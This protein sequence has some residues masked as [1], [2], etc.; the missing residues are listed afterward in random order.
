MTDAGVALR[1]AAPDGVGVTATDRTG[2]AATNT[3]AGAAVAGVGAGAAAAVAGAG[4]DA[5]AAASW[6]LGATASAGAAAA[7]AAAGA[8]AGAAGAAAAAAGA[9]V[10]PGAGEGSAGDCGGPPSP[11]QGTQ[12][13]LAP[14]PVS[15]CVE[16]GAGA[17]GRRGA[18]A[19]V[20][21][22]GGAWWAVQSGVRGRAWG[23]GDGARRTSHSLPSLPLRLV[24]RAKCE[25]FSRGGPCP[26]NGASASVRGRF[27]P[28]QGSHA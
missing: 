2:G 22:G 19:G 20:G 15:T 24:P 8:G 21:R 28:R 17:G 23:H 1:A 9:A 26:S 16:G 14:G 7:R 25:A 27:C 13:S 18:G 10:A 11:L 3:G 4:A 5:A 6:P 12:M